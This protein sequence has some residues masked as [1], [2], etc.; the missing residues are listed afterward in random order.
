MKPVREWSLRA[1][2]AA[3]S[4]IS[5]SLGLSEAAAIFG[6]DL[7][8]SG[9]PGRLGL[10]AP[11]QRRSGSS[12]VKAAGIAPMPAQARQWARMAFWACSRFSASSQTAERGPSITASVTS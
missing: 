7:E 4:P 11:R 2:A 6:V 12:A 1:E 8:Q 9:T 3:A 10:L 5:R